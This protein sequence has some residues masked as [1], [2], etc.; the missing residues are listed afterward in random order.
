MKKML[1]K[2][3][4]FL[5]ALIMSLCMPMMAQNDIKG[6]ALSSSTIYYLK[7]VGTGLHLKYGGSMGL[8]AAE[9]KPSSVLPGC[10][11]QNKF[12]P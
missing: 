4:M 2:R 6:N 7:N 5:V 12:L 8:H 11:Y 1:G 10:M 9:G 3:T